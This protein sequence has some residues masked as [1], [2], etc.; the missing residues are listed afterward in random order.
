MKL[1]SP[2]P[3]L[4]PHVNNLAGTSTS[5]LQLLTKSLY[6]AR[7]KFGE[8]EAKLKTF[9]HHVVTAVVVHG[10]CGSANGLNTSV[11]YLQMLEY[12]LGFGDES[13][14]LCKRVTSRMKPPHNI[15]VNTWFIRTFS[16]LWTQLLPALQQRNI[17]PTAEPFRACVSENVYAFSAT[18]GEKKSTGVPSPAILNTVG[19]PCGDCQQLRKFLTDS[20]ASW[21][22]KAVKPRRVHLEKALASSKALTWGIRWH[23]GG[24]SPQRLMVRLIESFAQ[25]DWIN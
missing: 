7:D 20:D 21:Q 16:P 22:F 13:L 25:S 8:N 15:P 12:C 18:I 10:P 5:A 4:I 24:G 3:S 9:V 11:A 23:T 14:A 19:C 2:L 17:S 6:A 1:T